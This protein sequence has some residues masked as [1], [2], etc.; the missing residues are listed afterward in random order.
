MLK[1]AVLQ[2]CYGSD[3]HYL[4]RV[5]DVTQEDVLDFVASTNP[6]QYL[7]PQQKSLLSE[8]LHNVESWWSSSFDAMQVGM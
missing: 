7:T 8:L 3:F 2:H 6:P 1:T 5:P 4:S